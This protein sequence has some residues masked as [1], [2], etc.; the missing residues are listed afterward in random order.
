GTATPIRLMIGTIERPFLHDEGIVVWTMSRRIAEAV[1]R[2]ARDELKQTLTP[3]ATAPAGRHPGGSEWNVEVEAERLMA[4]DLAVGQRAFAYSRTE[5]I[6][7][8]QRRRS[9]RC[10]GREKICAEL[11]ISGSGLP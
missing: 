2:V 5:Q 11:R 4:A 10:A 8:R 6:V 3:F 7:R 1:P 9:S